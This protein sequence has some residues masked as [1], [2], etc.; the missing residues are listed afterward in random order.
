MFADVVRL[1]RACGQPSWNGAAFAYD[2]P[3]S[4]D[5]QAAA[6]ACSIENF[7][8]GHFEGGVESVG[9]GTIEFLFRTPANERGRFFANAA[10][11]VQ[12]AKA[13][14]GGSLPLAY[15]LVGEDY[16]SGELNV[17][18]RLAQALLL[19]RLAVLLGRIASHA[20]EEPDGPLRLTFNLPPT[21]VEAP[22]AIILTTRITPDCL[23]LP[24]PDL[25][26]L[27]AL[28]SPGADSQL[29]VHEYR[30]V[31]RMSVTEVLAALPERDSSPRFDYLVRSWAT[32][33]QRDQFNTEIYVS[34]FSFNKLKSDIAKT[35]LDFAGRVAAVLGDSTGKLLALPLSAAAIAAMLKVATVYEALALLISVIIGGVLILAVAKNQTLAYQRVSA[36]FELAMSDLVDAERQRPEAL[37]KALVDARAGFKSQADHLVNVTAAVRWLAWAVMLA[38]AG[39]AAYRFVPWSSV[40]S[41]AS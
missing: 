6:T 16:L 22:R 7:A 40:T 37:S 20:S 25:S 8:F 19:S 30:Q 36:G 13:V 39:I 38:V 5:I 12:E 31:F 4:A 26:K 10:A 2:G 35:E 18:P 28:L 41:L 23:E 27:E 1:Y 21:A 15:Y 11:F 9:D 3:I 24:A 33:L 17:P 32:V 34:K 29:H 14:S